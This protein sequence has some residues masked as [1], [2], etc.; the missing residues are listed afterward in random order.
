MGRRIRV[1][2][3]LVGFLWLAGCGT[4]EQL[5]PRIAYEYAPYQS[6]FDNGFSAGSSDIKADET[7]PD[8]ADIPA[9]WIPS[10]NVEKKWT[11]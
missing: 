10:G 2:C 3:W 9:L 4:N 7:P 8:Y 1:I 5:A 6:G 11:N